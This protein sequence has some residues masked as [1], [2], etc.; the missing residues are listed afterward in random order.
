MFIMLARVI[1]L[2][3][4]AKASTGFKLSWL[5]KTVTVKCE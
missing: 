3:P 2:L 4:R 5:A 1:L